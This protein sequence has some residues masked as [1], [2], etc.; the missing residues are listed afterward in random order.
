MT[1]LEDRLVADPSQ[2]G[3][4]DP[5]IAELGVRH[6]I[7]T[8]LTSFVAVDEQSQVHGEPLAIVQPSE[9]ADDVRACY[10]MSQP[11]AACFDRVP[12]P[13]LSMDASLDCTPR[14]KQSPRA[15]R[16]PKRSTTADLS[17]ATAFAAAEV[18]NRDPAQPM[19]ERLAFLVL[20]AALDPA[21]AIPDDLTK[22]ALRFVYERAKSAGRGG[23]KLQLLTLAGSFNAGDGAGVLAFVLHLSGA[24][25][26]EKI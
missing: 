26:I 6:Q 2:K 13:S 8:R 24:A 12:A 17:K 9:R 4:I 14:F 5:E 22:D 16:S 19:T 10:A 20:I 11:V 21:N 23:R 25:S 1:E 7:Q 15:L 18:A 3:I